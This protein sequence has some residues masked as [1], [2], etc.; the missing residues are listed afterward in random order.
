[1]TIQELEK[2]E[3]SLPLSDTFYGELWSTNLIN[4]LQYLPMKYGAIQ[5]FEEAMI[6]NEGL[7]FAIEIFELNRS[8]FFSLCF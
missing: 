7:D 4:K 5:D 6:L 2:I 8:E 3:V 1:M